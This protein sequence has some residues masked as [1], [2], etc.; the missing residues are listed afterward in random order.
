[1]QLVAE[2]VAHMDA[3]PPRNLPALLWAAG[4]LGARACAPPAPGSSRQGSNAAA[5][6]PGLSRRVRRALLRLLGPGPTAQHGATGEQASGPPAAPPALPPLEAVQLLA[7]LRALRVGLPGPLVGRLA[8]EVALPAVRQVAAAARR[9]GAPRAELLRQLAALSAGLAGVGA[10]A[11]PQPSS[12]SAGVPRERRRRAVAPLRP[13]GLRAAGRALWAAAEALLGPAERGVRC[14]GEPT[15][16]ESGEPC[17]EGEGSPGAAGE[18]PCGTVALRDVAALL[19]GEAGREGP[20]GAHAH[21]G[22]AAG[23]ARRADLRVALPLGPVGQRRLR[24]AP[25]RRLA[26]PLAALLGSPGLAAQLAAAWPRCVPW[27][28]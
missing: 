21:A 6:L 7:A 2:A 5:P 22:A 12:P 19:C 13:P 10:A 26:A 17:R 14:R 20:C 23:L 15:D 24:L 4:Q 28:R 1:M 18:G 25:P 3:A 9:A 8:R 11:T 27:L 16:A